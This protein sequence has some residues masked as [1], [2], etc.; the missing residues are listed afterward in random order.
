[1][2][3][4]VGIGP[5]RWYSRGSRYGAE[6]LTFKDA[7]IFG[8]IGLGVFGAWGAV[9]GLAGSWGITG[10]V[11]G[12]LFLIGTVVSFVD[13]TATI[14]FLS[15]WVYLGLVRLGAI[16]VLLGFF[17]WLGD[18]VLRGGSA[19]E[20]VLSL[21]RLALGL[22]VPFGMLFGP[23]LVIDGLLQVWD[24]WRRQEPGAEGSG[25]TQV[26]AP[27]SDD[28]RPLSREERREW[29]RE[30]WRLYRAA[31][32]PSAAHLRDPDW[33]LSRTPEQRA[34]RSRVRPKRVSRD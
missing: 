33:W 11:F 28:G 2:P 4:S 32:R 29:R 34:Y 30:S 6:P 27:V 17:E 9:E 1:M 12:V 19:D 20:F 14:V 15:S 13:R 21:L 7:V 26:V 23:P 18:P 24:R 10:R 5:F 16:D 25:V 31:M 3:F 8:V 22:A